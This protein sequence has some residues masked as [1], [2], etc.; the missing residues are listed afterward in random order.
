[1]NAN[2]DRVVS[3]AGFFALLATLAL[4]GPSAGEPGTDAVQQARVALI[5]AAPNA[6]FYMTG[7]RITTVYGAPVST[8]DT[9][10]ASA[11]AFVRRYSVLFGV[12]PAELVPESI[13][14]D[15]R[16]TQPVWFQR[17]S[18]TYKFTLVYYSQNRDG[19]PVYMADLRLLCRNE[20][21]LPLV[22]ARSALRDLRE[23]HVP[24][25]AGNRLID[26]E[27]AHAVADAERKDAVFTTYTPAQLVVW[28]GI[29]DMPALPA[30]CYEFIAESAAP[31]DAGY[32]RWRFLVDA[33]TLDAGGRA[34]IRYSE[35]LVVHVDVTGTVQT[36]VTDGYAAAECSQGLYVT[37]AL[38][39]ARVTIG[40]TVAY[41]DA[42]GN[43]TIP[44]AG[45]TDVTVQS[46]V[47]GRWFKVLDFPVSDAT[48]LSQTVT[49]PGP[50]NFL[51]NS[52]GSENTTAEVNAYVAANQVRDHI[53]RYNPIFPTIAT[54]QE[55]PLVV[56]WYAHCLNTG[57]DGTSIYFTAAGDPNNACNNS[58]FGTVVHH[59]FGHHA[60]NRAGSGQG[61]YGE[62]F[63]D[64]MAVI[65]TDSPDVGVGFRTGCA[66]YRPA[67]NTNH[68]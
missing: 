30:L 8:G 35:N 45:S 14:D 4:G 27:K 22:L 15:K 40:T 51:H 9:P 6:G 43:F 46:G 19:Y 48:L 67:N 42:G 47:R 50:A 68:D 17:E 60:V 41:A 36:R 57:Y 28:A 54:Q 10:E 29:D 18:G 24:A 64:C 25:D 58:A 23:F 32:A 20:P 56:N 55:F 12:S 53:L 49:P 31:G 13:L 63:G 1:M 62:G 38:P 3:R 21:G 65:V 16:H 33:L 7:D 61:Q 66:V 5:H 52:D 34:I 37:R 44:N 59:E 11:D 2:H 26:I 39:Y